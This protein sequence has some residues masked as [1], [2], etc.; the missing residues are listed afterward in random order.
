[1]FG[2]GDS[3]DGHDERV[4]E[5]AQRLDALGYTDIHADHTSEYPDPEMRNGRIADVTADSPFGS[6]PVVE[7]DSGQGS[8]EHAQE[9]LDDLS[10]GLGPDEELVHVDSDDDLFGGL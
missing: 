5:Q 10:S 4:E 8:S 1:M 3:D 7:I 6:D 9:Q 2:F